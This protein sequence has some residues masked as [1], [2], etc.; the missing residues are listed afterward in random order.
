MRTTVPEPAA[1]QVL[2]RNL[3]LSLD[4]GMRLRMSDVGVPLPLYTVGAVMDGDAVGEVVRSASVDLA[5]GDLVHHGLGWREYAV[6]DA[7]RF[8]R[9]DDTAFPTV[10]AHLASYLTAWVGVVDVARMAPGDTVFV[11]GAA[12]SVGGLAGQI[13]RLKGAGRVVGSVGSPAKAAHVTGRLGFDAAFDHHDGRHADRLREVAPDGVDVY[14][15]NTGGAQLEAAIEVMNPHGRIA[16]CGALAAQNGGTGAAGPSNLILAIGKRLTMRGFLTSDHLDRAK[17][18]HTDVA[19]WLR[20][21]SLTLDQTIVDGLE[22]APQAFIDMLGGAYTGKVVVRLPK[23][24]RQ[25]T[26]V[27]GGGGGANR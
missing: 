2:V 26:V 24:T 5:V 7:A 11:S 13:A 23:Q 1:G 27:R 8:R 20:D 4:A 9:I 22:N 18:A 15:D 21:G 6:A 12:G 10:S 14:F 19:G 17:Q 16:L 25:A 3:V